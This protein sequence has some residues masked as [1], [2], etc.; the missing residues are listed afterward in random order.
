MYQTVQMLQEQKKDGVRKNPG[1]R[2]PRFHVFEEDRDIHDN[3]PGHMYP[4]RWE[5]GHPG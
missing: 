2:I 4:T 5:R 3:F 1:K